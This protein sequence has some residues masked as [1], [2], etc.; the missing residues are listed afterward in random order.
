VRTKKDGFEVSDEAR[1]RALVSKLGFG[2]A[3][4]TLILH[5]S[6]P[7]VITP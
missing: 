5:S 3:R 6:V 7:T 4:V 1:A 2:I